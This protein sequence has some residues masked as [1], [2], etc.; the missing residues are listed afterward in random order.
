MLEVVSQ[1]IV[2]II[3]GQKVM[4]EY[5]SR[6]GCAIK[7]YFTMKD[8]NTLIRREMHAILQSI[9]E[10]TGDSPY[11]VNVTLY[12]LPFIS[13]LPF[14]NWRGGIEI[15]EWENSIT[16]YF[17]QTRMAIRDLQTRGLMVWADDVTAEDLSMWLRAGVNGY[18]VELQEIRN[19]PEFLKTLQGTKKPIIVE[20]IETEVEHQ[21]IKQKGITLAQGYYYGRPERL[22]KVV[23]FQAVDA[24]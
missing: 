23:Q 20:R 9:E 13:K 18:K 24:Y 2:N 21:W 3:T 11:N 1:P 15:V 22:G 17:K 10:S 6:P 19:N 4:E 7:D 14:I 12:T 5:L 16:P 8:R